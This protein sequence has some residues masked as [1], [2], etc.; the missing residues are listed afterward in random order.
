M[1]AWKDL[2]ARLTQ[3]VAAWAGGHVLSIYRGTP[4][5]AWLAKPWAQVEQAAQ[6]QMPVLVINVKGRRVEQ[7]L[8]LMPLVN[9]ER[10]LTGRASPESAAATVEQ[11]K[12]QA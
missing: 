5:P 1:A 7:T 9:L 3:G 11:V 6:G 10:L 12:R 4:L 2:E 8:C